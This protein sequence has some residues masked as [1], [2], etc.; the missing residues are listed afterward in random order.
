MST[1]ELGVI[2][3]C[4]IASL[5]DRRGHALSAAGLLWKRTALR[6]DVL[7]E[8][9]AKNLRAAPGVLGWRTTA[10]AR[11]LGFGQEVANLLLKLIGPGPEARRRAVE[12]SEEVGVAVPGRLDGERTVRESNEVVL[13]SR[14]D[15]GGA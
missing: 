6:Q 2:G 14:R 11:R 8:Y 15:A 12:R 4:A 13:E 3:N 9:A 5:I 7:R 10:S 1:L